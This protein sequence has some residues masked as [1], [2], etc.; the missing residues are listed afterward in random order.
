[1]SF[2]LFPFIYALFALY[3]NIILI[4]SVKRKNSAISNIFPV[5]LNSP[6]SHAMTLSAGLADE[7]ARVAARAEKARVLVGLDGFVDTILHPVDA[8][9]GPDEFIRI[10][11]IR[12]FADRIAAA[13]GRSANLE[14][15]TKAVRFGGNGPLLANGL[16]RLG[17][18][19]DYIGCVGLHDPHPAF[20]DF[21]SRV[22]LHSIGWPGFTDAV[23]FEDGKLML[24]KHESLRGISWDSMLE[25]V[26]LPE[27][28]SLA[29]NAQL[30]AWVN[31]TCIDRMSEILEQFLAQVAAELTGPKRMAFFDLADPAKRSQAALQGVLELIG[32]YQAR[33]DV[34]LGMNFAE[35]RKIAQALGLP[36]P[37]E[38]ASSALE[39]AAALRI[40][41]GIE[42]VTIHQRRWAVAVTMRERVCAP[43]LFVPQPVTTTGAGDHYNAGFCLGLLGRASLDECVGSGLATA[44]RY[45]RTGS[46]PTLSELQ[47][48]LADAALLQ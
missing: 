24:G 2:C 42:A 36:A 22:R 17:M 3:W 21:A 7:L 38:E 11:K 27:L 31:W 14:L 41:L 8:R 40:S 34:V 45:I 28:K 5:M 46:S 19:V 32:A 47:C 39:C 6:D 16:A 10:G 12:D 23:E 9:T 43:S 29:A 35:A 33:F 20:G 15:V 25:R 44:G 30:I 18:S 48:F 26:P 13:S 4:T 37:S 1:M